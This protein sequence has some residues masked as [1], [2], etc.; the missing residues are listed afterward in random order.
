MKTGAFSI[1]IS[2]LP[3][4][5]WME[6]RMLILSWIVDAPVQKK[7]IKMGMLSTSV[8][9][10]QRTKIFYNSKLQTSAQDF[11]SRLH[12]K[13]VVCQGFAAS[14]IRDHRSYAAVVAAGTSSGSSMGSDER[15]VL[16]LLPLKAFSTDVPP[17]KACHKP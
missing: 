8:H 10:V 2:V 14:N 12:M 3:V 9:Y 16:G 6:K 5:S 15:K 13:H 7:R 11:Q 17:N 1:D 4:G